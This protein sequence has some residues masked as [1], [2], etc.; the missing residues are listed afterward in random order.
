M[1]AAVSIL[2]WRWV[3]AQL[4]GH[5]DLRRLI[6]QMGLDSRGDPVWEDEKWYGLEEKAVVRTRHREI[7]KSEE[8]KLKKEG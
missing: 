6:G 4:G 2:A 7:E 8:K 3:A 5:R 1:E